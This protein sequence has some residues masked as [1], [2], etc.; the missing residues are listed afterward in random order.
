M[1][2]TNKESILKKERKRYVVNGGKILVFGDTHFSAKYNGRHKNYMYDCYVTMDLILKHVKEQQPSAVFFLGDLIGVNERNIYDHEFLMRVVMFFGSLYKITKGNVYYVKGNHDFGDFADVDFLTGLGYIKNPEYV[3]YVV[4]DE[5]QIRFHFVNYGDERKK[6]NIAEG[7]TSNVVLGHA[8]YYIEGVTSWYSS[9]KG[10]VELKTL[11]NFNGVELVFAGHIH[12]PSSEVL[13]TTLPNGES[14]GLFYLGS[15]SRVAERFDD[16]WY[17]SFEYSEES[18][19]TNYD[20]DVM[21]LP[22]ASEVFYPKEDFVDESEDGSESESEE[23]TKKETEVLDAIVNEIISTRLASGDVFK[24][25]DIIPADN[26]TKELAKNY[27][28]KA[29]EVN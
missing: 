2:E 21:G 15:P 16:C 8:D 10:S 20:A 28:R 1:G 6:L 4:E 18:G 29:M 9:K 13:Y 14:I 17:V 7:S 23:V 5:I 25:I 27:L 12:V 19:S 22:P 3:D 11:S 24:Q 26:E